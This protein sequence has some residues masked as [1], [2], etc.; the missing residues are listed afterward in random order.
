M[1]LIRRAKK[2]DKDG[3]LQLASVFHIG[4]RMNRNIVSKKLFELIKYRNYKKHI[5]EDV[6]NSLT[7]NKGI[8]FVAE[9]N[10][11][12]VGYIYGSVKLQ[13]KKILEKVGYVEDWFMLDG[14]R[15]KG[16]GRK[17]WAKLMTWFKSKKCDCIEL[18][19]YPENE[20]SKK[21]YRK[22]GLIEKDIIMGKKL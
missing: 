3:L 9:Q 11:Q 17:L 12:L 4:T 16:I 8:V 6:S 15:H 18:K 20:P 21:I 14:F 13:P 7:D 10:G 19:V 1:V 22:L 2:S 5:I